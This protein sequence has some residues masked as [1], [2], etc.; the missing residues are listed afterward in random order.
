MPG[1]AVILKYDMV[2]MI[3]MPDAAV[4][5]KYN[6]TSIGTE[7]DAACSRPEKTMIWPNGV[8]M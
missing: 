7:P 2:T 3:A 5:L 1:A 8:K 6:M 4:N